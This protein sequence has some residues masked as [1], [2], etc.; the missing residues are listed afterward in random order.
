M[1]G[2]KATPQQAL[3]HA[4]VHGPLSLRRADL[5]GDGDAV[6]EIDDLDPG[7]ALLHVWDPH[8]AP[9]RMQRASLQQAHCMRM[10]KKQCQAHCLPAR[11]RL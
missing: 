2:N 7:H 3:R 8:S 10:H 11:C 4:R 1:H 6:M 5:H 9:P